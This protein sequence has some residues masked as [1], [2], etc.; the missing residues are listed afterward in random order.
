M[1]VGLI[2]DTTWLNDE[3]ATLK[4]LVV[5]LIGEQVRVA[6][7]VPTR[8]ARDVPSPFVE[9]V[10]WQDSRRDFLRRHRLA[11][12]AHALDELGVEV[13]HAVDGRLWH[14]VLMLAERLG[15]P[16][17]LNVNAAADL[18]RI[19]ALRRQIGACRVAFST[20]TPQLTQAVRQHTSDPSLV[21]T[22]AFGT[23]V[24]A[25]PNNPPAGGAL[26]VVITGNGSLDTHY[27]SLFAAMEQF[28]AHCHGALFFFDGLGADQHSLWKAARRHRLLPHASMVPAHL[29]RRDLLMGAHALVHPQPLGW[30]RSMTLQAMAYGLTVLAQRD[31]WLDYLEHDRTAWLLDGGDP[32]KPAGAEAWLT[33]LG[34]AWEDHAGAARLHESARQ[35]VRQ[36]HL[37]ATHVDKTIRLYRQLSGESYP[38]EAAHEST[39]IR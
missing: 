19:V 11:R 1:Y 9:Q 3:R 23:H 12:V 28:V 35:W 34:R 18:N 7:V 31:P 36:R 24:P 13:L 8:T 2:T 15:L 20:A 26:C 6:Q 25:Q 30:A 32:G 33:L 10:V 37:A 22:I 4:S 17:V 5:G 29:S 38:F 16:A 27:Q 39:E 21:D 14:G